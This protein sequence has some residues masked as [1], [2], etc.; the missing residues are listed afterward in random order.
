VEGKRRGR[1]G[2]GRGK[3]GRKRRRNGREG[4]R[5]LAPT[6]KNPGAATAPQAPYSK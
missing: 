6:E 2:K 1:E 5:D 3:G 4:E